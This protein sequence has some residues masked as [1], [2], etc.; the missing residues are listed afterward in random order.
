MTARHDTTGPLILGATGQV[1]QALARVWPEGAGIWQYR[2]GTARHVIAGFP[3]QGLE[4]DILA[5]PLPPLPEVPPGIIV[6]ALS[7]IHI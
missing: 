3:G 2:P 6:L 4:W 5:A 7:L 1:G